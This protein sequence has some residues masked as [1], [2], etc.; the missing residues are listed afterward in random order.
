MPRRQ[1][2]ALFLKTVM[3]ER[4]PKG[5]HRP[6]VLLLQGGRDPIAPLRDV[7]SLRRRVPGASLV[8]INGGHVLP[9]TH[10]HEVVSAV[11][12]FLPAN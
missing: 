12:G 2:H 4:R 7:D 10:A 9:V 1:D 6:R 11:E 5:P 3:L 8:T